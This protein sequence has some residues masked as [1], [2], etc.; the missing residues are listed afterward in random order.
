MQVMQWVEGAPEMLIFVAVLVV[1]VLAA[2]VDWWRD[3]DFDKRDADLVKKAVDAIKKTL[4]DYK[5]LY[6]DYMITISVVYTQH[7]F[8][9][10]PDV[11]M[12]LP[13]YK[14]DNGYYRNTD[15]DVVAGKAVRDSC[16][17]HLSQLSRHRDK[18]NRILHL[19][20]NHKPDKTMVS[21]LD[22]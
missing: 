1:L 5:R 9:D 3:N 4:N 15:P 13:N 21:I 22:G 10:E 19:K 14:R 20:V 7:S 6:G 11:R 16:F 17:L 18:Q 12:T 2:L 8:L